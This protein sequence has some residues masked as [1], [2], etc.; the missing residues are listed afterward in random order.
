MLTVYSGLST[1]PIDAA[2]STA[3]DESREKDSVKLEK[4][5]LTDKMVG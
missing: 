5:S 3:L 4:R 1:K 2:D